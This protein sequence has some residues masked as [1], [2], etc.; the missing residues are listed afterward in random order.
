ELG[1]PTIYMSDG[2]TGPREGQA[3]AMPSPLSQASSFDPALAYR[4]GRTIATEVRF[5]GNDILHAPTVDVMRL[6]QAGRTFATFREDP[7]LATRAG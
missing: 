7:Y 4:I 2:P 5:K 3:T 6:P 1:I